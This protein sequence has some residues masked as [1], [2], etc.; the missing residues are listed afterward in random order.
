MFDRK[1]SLPA[2]SVLLASLLVA[3]CG[4]G[5]VVSDQSAPASQSAPGQSSSAQAGG[6]QP[7]APAAPVAVASPASGPSP[8]PN[9][10]I[11]QAEAQ[12]GVPV[13]VPESLKR[14][15]TP[16]ELQ[17]AMQ[18]LPPEVRQRIM[19]LGQQ[20]RPSPTPEPAKKK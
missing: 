8:T 15:M 18:A 14:P 4:K 5:S 11:K 10:M 19:G 6:A 20:P 1:F 9:A 13:S 12:P 7:N 2:S 3:G 17:K 16:E